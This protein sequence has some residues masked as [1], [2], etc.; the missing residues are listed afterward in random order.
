MGVR[1]WKDDA[2]DLSGSALEGV[3]ERAR[4]GESERGIADDEPAPIE[5]REGRLRRWMH[6]RRGRVEADPSGTLAGASTP[7]AGSHLVDEGGVKWSPKMVVRGRRV[8]RLSTGSLVW[9]ED[10]DRPGAEGTQW[11]GVTE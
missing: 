4:D 3:A 5:R 11:L 2:L 10:A 1:A 7:E 9:E 8:H 6:A